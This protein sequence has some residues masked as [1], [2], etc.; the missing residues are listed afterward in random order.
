[1]IAIPLLNETEISIV[2]VLAMGR[3]SAQQFSHSAICPFRDPELVNIWRKGFLNYFY[4]EG[5]NSGF[6]EH[7]Y[8]HCLDKDVIDAIAC[9]VLDRT[10]HGRHNF[11]HHI[12]NWE[13]PK[14]Q[15]NWQKNG[16]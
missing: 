7:K 2:R 16:F 3:E 10:L 4:D 14:K 1:M 6:N 12:E 15:N 11:A 9:G 5:Y 8:Q 13:N